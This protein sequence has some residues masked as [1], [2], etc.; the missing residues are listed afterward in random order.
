MV[1]EKGSAVMTIHSDED[2]QLEVW[3]VESDAKA[4]E[5]AFGRTL[6]SNVTRT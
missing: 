1:V 5:K 4:F 6:S 2:V 3:G